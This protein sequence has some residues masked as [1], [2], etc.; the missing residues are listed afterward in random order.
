MQRFSMLQQVVQ[1]MVWSAVLWD[2]FIPWHTQNINF[3]FA[4]LVTL[5]IVFFE[6]AILVTHRIINF[7]LATASASLRLSESLEFIILCWGVSTLLPHKYAPLFLLVQ[8]QVISSISQ[9]CTAAFAS[10]DSLA[11]NNVI[12]GCHPS[13]AQNNKFQTR[14]GIRFASPNALAQNL[15]FYAV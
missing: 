6:F 15:L 9:I 4:I 10:P 5:C 11:W 3:Q 8:L 13:H 2:L 14:S 7:R 12:C 1:G